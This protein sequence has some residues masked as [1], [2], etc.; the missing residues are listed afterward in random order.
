VKQKID[1]KLL[2]INFETDA[3]YKISGLNEIGTAVEKDINEVDTWI[4]K[5]QTKIFESKDDI[6]MDEYGEKLIFV[7]TWIYNQNKNEFK[8][9]EFT[10]IAY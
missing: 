4:P 3:A 2:G 1:W 7:K 6:E 8:L 9:N 5:S 10:N